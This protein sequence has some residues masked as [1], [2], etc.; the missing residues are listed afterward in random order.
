MNVKIRFLHLILIFL[1]SM[2]GHKGLCDEGYTVAE[3]AK[4][5]EALD[6]NYESRFQ[7]WRRLLNMERPSMFINKD[8][9]NPARAKFEHDLNQARAD[10]D[11][12]EGARYRAQQAGELGSDNSED[13]G[14]R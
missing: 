5:V 9:P 6:K 13:Q 1:M 12:W 10:A 7:E 3:L 2:G 8:Q 4:Q 14:I 11:Y